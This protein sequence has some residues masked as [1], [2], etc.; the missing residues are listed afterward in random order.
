MDRRQF[1]KLGMTAGGLTMVG[2]A[3]AIVNAS[4]QVEFLSVLVD[5]T[6]CIGCRQCELACAQAN[7][8]PIPNINDKSVFNS[9][10]TTST[11]SL[12]VVNRF[13]TQKGTINVKRQCMHCNQPGCVSACLVAAMKKRK[14]GPVTW[15]TNCIGCRYCM[16]SCPFDV[17][18]FEYEKAAPKLK[19]CNFCFSRLK[20]GQL[21]ACVQACPAE[22]LLFGTRKKML[23]M[24]KSQI[25]KY[26]GQY[27]HHVYGEREAGGTSWLYMSSVPFD[28]IG[29]KT[30]LSTTPYPEFTKGFLYLVPVVFVLWPSLLLGINRLTER[31]EKIESSGDQKENTK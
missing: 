25:G 31:T 28:Q 21:P 1:L 13:E 8:L 9:V 22:A 7:G 20:K 15:D 24:A 14:Q 19:K 27:H 12:T 10:R 30:T 17:P 18:K 23:S 3:P 26:P 11:I 4:G 5:T 2:G 6:R 16:I 29:F